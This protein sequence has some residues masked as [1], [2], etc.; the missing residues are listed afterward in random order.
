MTRTCANRMDRGS[1]HLV[2]MCFPPW[3]GRM[4]GSVAV[5]I[6]IEAFPAPVTGGQHTLRFMFNEN[7]PLT[8]G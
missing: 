3:R 2:F 7:I 4:A 5:P 6:P 8:R 1:V